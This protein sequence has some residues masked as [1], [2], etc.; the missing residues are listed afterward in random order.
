MTQVERLAAWIGQATYADF[1]EEVRRALMIHILAQP[2]L[3]RI[4]DLKEFYHLPLEEIDCIE[5]EIFDVAY[6]I[7]GRG[8]EGNKQHVQTKEE[9]DHSLPYLIAVALLDGAVTPAQ[10]TEDR[11][12]RE[13][14]QTLLRKVRVRPDEA[15]HARFPA[16]M[17]C[18]LRVVLSGN[19]VLELDKHDY[20]GFFTRPFTWEQAQAKFERLTT[21]YAEHT[22]RQEL[23]M[24]ILLH[25]ESS[26][27]C[28]RI[29]L[30]ASVKTRS[31]Q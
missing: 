14:V 17:P 26:E 28:K 24:E 10:Y 21:P 23:I 13:D 22:R 29:D 20:A 16:A 30:L 1:A 19:R 3:E 12:T 9:A 7:I 15:L 8:E 2:A 4:L 25:L 5:V 18:R 11:I 6:H 31:I 27:V